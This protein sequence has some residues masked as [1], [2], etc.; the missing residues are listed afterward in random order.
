MTIN[1]QLQKDWVQSMKERNKQLSGVLSM[2]RAAILQAEKVDNHEVDDQEALQILAKEIKQRRE[3]ITEFE[4]GNRTDLVEQTNFEI[5][6]LMN[7]LPE[8]MS[9][10]EIRVLIKE[11]A[12]LLGANN[13][14][15][16]GKLMQAIKPLTAGKA[17]GKLLGDLA[18]Q[19]LN[20]EK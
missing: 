13:I 7:Y 15:D 11:Q 4:K 18:K 8:Q 19:Y 9:E 16:M 1:E 5:E 17:D 10:D 2:A 6:T 14:K 3:A 12:E 20:A